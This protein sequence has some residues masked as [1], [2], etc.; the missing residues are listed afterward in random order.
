M[1]AKLGKKDFIL[2]GLLAVI[3]IGVVYYMC[4]LTPFKS[5]LA[6]IKNQSVSLDDQITAL[7]TKIA[8]MDKMQAEL[9]EI[10][11][12]PKDEITEI[13]PYDNAKTVMNFLNGVLAQSN[14]YSLSSPDPA[15]DNSGIVRRNV[16]LSFSCSDYATAKT[17]L[18]SLASWNYRCL[19]GNVTISAGGDSGSSVNAS[20]VSVN[21]SM[22]FFESTK[23]S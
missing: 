10:F 1:N 7:N 22:T 6:D 12:R 23:I 14:E 2:V 4:F 9:D 17:I 11:S 8:S 13:A 5:D 19:L 3:V 18:K 15:I 20:G 16:T 21:A